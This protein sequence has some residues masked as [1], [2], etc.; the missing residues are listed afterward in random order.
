MKNPYTKKRRRKKIFKKLVFKLVWKKSDE[1]FQRDTRWTRLR[2]RHYGNKRWD[3]I[4]LIDAQWKRNGPR[5]TSSHHEKCVSEQMRFALSRWWKDTLFQKRHGLTG[6]GCSSLFDPSLPKVRSAKIHFRKT[7]DSS[8][9]FRVFCLCPFQKR[10]GKSG[11]TVSP[12]VINNPARF[13]CSPRER[14]GFFWREEMRST[15]LFLFSS[16]SLPFH[17]I[18]HA[19]KSFATRVSIT[20]EILLIIG[21][22]IHFSFLSKSDKSFLLFDTRL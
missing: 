5:L 14:I 9:L 16:S 3:E 21:R 12:F 15:A 18:D 4:S 6:G 19:M 8:F 1:S 22:N 20:R 11:N 17:C 13:H 10:R 2:F 7:R